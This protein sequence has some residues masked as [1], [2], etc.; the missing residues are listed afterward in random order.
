MISISPSILLFHDDEDF[1]TKPDLSGVMVA[2]SADQ[3][4]LSQLTE[5]EDIDIHIL[6]LQHKSDRY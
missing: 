2:V 6:Q 5:A 1:Q 4:S 3:Q